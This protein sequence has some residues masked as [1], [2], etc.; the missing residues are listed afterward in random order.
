MEL[1][2]ITH[3]LLHAL[4]EESVADRLD[5]ARSQQ[6]VYAILQE[7]SYF[8]ISMEEFQRGI[9]ALKEEQGD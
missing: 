2:E 1:D 8:T 4:T 5:A 7:L 6:E 9:A 3:V